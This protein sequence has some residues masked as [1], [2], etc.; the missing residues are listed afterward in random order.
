MNSTRMNSTRFISPITLG[1]AQL[2][3]A[4]GV[5]NRTGMPGDADANAVL[6]AAWNG[7]VHTFDTARVYGQAE[8]RIGAWV[9]S[10]RHRPYVITKAPK[11]DGDVN[12]PDTV[13]HSVSS[14]MKA[15][16]L[17][18]IDGLMMHSAQDIFR[19]GVLDSLE[20]LKTDG[21]IGG[22]GIS[23]YAPEDVDKA[24]T[25][26]SLSLVQAPFNLFDRRMETSGVLDRCMAAGV[27]VFA[28]SLFLQ[29]LFFLNPETLPDYLSAAAEPLRQLRAYADDLGRSVAE[30]AL[31]AVRD[32]PGVASLVVGAECADQVKDTLAIS[33]A[34]PL[35]GAERKAV[36]HI[37]DGLP[38]RIYHPGLWG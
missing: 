35:S 3:Q 7:G 25:V 15:L 2:G 38:E 34:A 26:P 33:K 32:T 21:V 14:S 5:A 4:Y 12:I 30:V 20:K 24:L 23:A 10:S 11:L 31:V 29:G 36:F 37:G 27:T 18:F 6:D 9:A 8:A 17:D 1:T 22:F 19:P 16:N 13:Q 28:R